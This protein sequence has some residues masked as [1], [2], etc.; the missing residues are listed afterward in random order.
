MI[1]ATKGRCAKCKLGTV[2]IC[3]VHKDCCAC[4]YHAGVIIEA[5]LIIKNKGIKDE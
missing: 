2:C 4:C 5:L 3:L 1:D